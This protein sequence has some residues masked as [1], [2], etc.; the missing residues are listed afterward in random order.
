M[1]EHFE[2][3][4]R[5][6]ANWLDALADRLPVTPSEGAVERVKGAVRHELNAQ[7]LE[8]QAEPE[9][10][11]ET[12]ER[13]KSAVRLEL[14]RQDTGPVA[15][16]AATL[17]WLRWGGRL[18]AAAVIG[19]VVGHFAGWFGGEAQPGPEQT[20][21]AQV[22]D[23]DAVE[24]LIAT[25]DD[26]LNEYAQTDGAIANVSITDKNVDLWTTERQAELE[27]VAQMMDE[28]DALLAE[29]AGRTDRVPISSERQGAVG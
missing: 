8:Q 16:P 23:A 11:V 17:G 4:E 18:A 6:V 13:V 20:I 5:E 14:A 3:R 27:E 12:V 28:I 10:S 26:V 29:P 1:D 9:P 22:S 19:L 21:V 25:V 2:Q 15:V 7:W 24:Q